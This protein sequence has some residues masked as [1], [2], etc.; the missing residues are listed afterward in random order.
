MELARLIC[1]VETSSASSAL[2]TRF[3][4]FPANEWS[5]GKE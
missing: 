4:E 2:A 1:V 5:P 3:A